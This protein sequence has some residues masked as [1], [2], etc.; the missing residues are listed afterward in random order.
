MSFNQFQH[1]EKDIDTTVTPMA[2]TWLSVMG[3]CA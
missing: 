1:L 2:F 3:W